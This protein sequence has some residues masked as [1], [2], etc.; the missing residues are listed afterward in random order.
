VAAGPEAPEGGCKC[1]ENHESDWRVGKLVMSLVEHD[2]VQ[3]ASVQALR[4]V[5]W[6]VDPRT[7]QPGDARGLQARHEADLL[8]RDPCAAR[9]LGEKLG[10]PVMAVHLPEDRY[11]EE[12]AN[13]GADRSNYPEDV[14][15]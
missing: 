3:L 5:G 2:R 7:S 13:H 15:D 6:T 9:R 14:A 11:G 4:K 10:Q 8:I 1:G 12:A